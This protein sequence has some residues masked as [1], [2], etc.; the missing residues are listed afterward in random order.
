MPRKTKPDEKAKR[1][2]MTP[3]TPRPKPKADFPLEALDHKNVTL[4]KQY[5]TENGRMLPRKY[6]G[7]PAKY[8]RLLSVAIKRARYMLLM[9]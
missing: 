7:L 6:T 5:V 2:T 1:R 9:K 3:R 8:Q 4:L